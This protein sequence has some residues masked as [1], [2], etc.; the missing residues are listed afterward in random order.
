[1]VQPDDSVNKTPSDPDQMLD[2]KALAAEVGAKAARAILR[3]SEHSG[4][5]RKPVIR[6]VDAEEILELLKRE[7]TV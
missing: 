6:R 7:G 1:M 3:R 4:R 5:K 2:M